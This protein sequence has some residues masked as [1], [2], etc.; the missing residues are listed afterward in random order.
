MG[1]LV[2]GFSTHRPRQYLYVL[3]AGLT[4]P[5]LELWVSIICSG[6][7]SVAAVIVCWAAETPFACAVE[8]TGRGLRHRGLRPRRPVV[9]GCA[10]GRAGKYVWRTPAGRVAA[11]ACRG[12][13]CTRWGR[14][15]MPVFVCVYVRR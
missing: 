4:S 8:L 15:R 5:R 13:L 14:L 3:D 7:R 11:A 2:P 12:C 9:S 1:E 10:G 6:S